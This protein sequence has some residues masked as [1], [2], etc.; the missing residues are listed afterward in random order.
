MPSVPP[1]ITTAC[2]PFIFRS[3]INYNT[4]KL[5]GET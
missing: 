1:P 2:F 5:D 3:T 4:R